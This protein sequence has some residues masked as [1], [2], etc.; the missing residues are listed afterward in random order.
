[1]SK[2]MDINR[3]FIVGIVSLSSMAAVTANAQTTIHVPADQP[4]I[5]SGIDTAINGDTV[6]V[7]PGTYSEG[8]DFK[9]KAITVTSSA[10]AARTIID[11]SQVYVGVLFGSGET[12]ASVLN[13]FTIQNAGNNHW[14]NNAHAP[15]MDGIQI[16]GANPTITN[17]IITHNHG[18]GVEIN[19][20][21]AIITGNTISYTTTQYDPNQDF[22]CDYDDGSGIQVSG[23]ASIS[24][25]ISNN[26]IEHNKAQCDGGAIRLW[27]AAGVPNITNNII[28]YNQAY[29]GGGGAIAMFNGFRVSIIQNLIYGNIAFQTGG[30]L[31]LVT[32]NG[33]STT[34][35]LS[36]FL[37]NN[38]IVGNGINT[39]TSGT[40]ISV[41]TQIEFA[42]AAGQAGFFNNLIISGDSFPEIACDPTYQY[43]SAGPPV[44]QNNDIF[45]Y[46]GPT[47]G[48]WCPDPAGSN[49][50]VS[51]DPRFTTS[52]NQFF[53]LQSGSAA[54]DSGTN[55]APNLPILDLN[56]NPR[57]QNGVVDMGVYEGGAPGSTN[58]SQ[59]GFSISASQAS[60]TVLPGHSQSVSLTLTP[61]GGYT[62]SISLTRSTPPAYALYFFQPF[63][64]L[65]VP[66][67]NSTLST[68]FFV[69][70]AASPPVGNVVRDSHSPAFLSLGSFIGLMG[71]F[72]L[73][74]GK[75]KQGN[76][77][78]HSI[79]FIFF[80]VLAMSVITETSCGGNGSSGGSS[81]TTSNSSTFPVVITATGIG[82]ASI[83]KTVTINVTIPPQ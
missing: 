69:T 53:H 33:G 83:S 26:I 41:G 55:S 76:L 59:N 32:G 28:R 24:T 45:N 47:F 22:G 30:G 73:N 54:I 43:L 58:S 82:N 42:A 66:G 40:A 60:L 74:N 18:Y 67:D 11:A 78:R 49:G 8:I 31:Y 27:A 34:N 29:D 9:G 16:I 6:L 23:D 20:G 68:N 2:S 63:T 44:T 39:T 38:T 46:A 52:S 64:V 13:G 35:P 80:F 7:A 17:N 48:G 3:Y 71:L 70:N 14:P 5:Q 36:V 79:H 72:L 19:F 37:V 12:Q 56:G 15:N 65:A 10:G 77:P 25:V 4:T 50:N 1:M 51:A 57:I 62:G 61:T 81:T 21:S 75:K